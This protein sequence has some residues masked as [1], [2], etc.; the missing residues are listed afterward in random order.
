[1]NIYTLIYTWVYIY[2]Y[3]YVYMVK[4]WFARQCEQHTFA[5]GQQTYILVGQ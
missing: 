1:M 2:K 3:M 4:G 5:K